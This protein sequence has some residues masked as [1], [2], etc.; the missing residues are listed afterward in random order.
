MAIKSIQLKDSDGNN[1]YPYSYPRF[2]YRSIA[3][4]RKAYSKTVNTWFKS[5]LTFTIEGSRSLIRIIWDFNSGAPTGLAVARST[6]ASISNFTWAVE[7]NPGH[8]LNLLCILDAGTYSVWL[9]SS[10]ENPNNN[11]TVYKIAEVADLG[12]WS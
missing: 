11:L 1:L 7:A 6:G 8:T 2:S 5:D 10:G 4:E 9:R 3:S 12:F